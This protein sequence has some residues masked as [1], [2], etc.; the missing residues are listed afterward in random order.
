[1][2]LHGILAPYGLVYLVINENYYLLS[3]KYQALLSIFTYIN[4]FNNQYL[5]VIQYIP[6]LIDEEN[7]ALK[8]KIDLVWTPVLRQWRPTFSYLAPDLLS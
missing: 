2:S 5:Q 6:H 3:T 1:M 4:S 7:E 8:R